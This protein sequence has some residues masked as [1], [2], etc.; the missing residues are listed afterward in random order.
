MN[1]LKA[2]R[3]RTHLL[4]FSTSCCAVSSSCCI[5][6]ALPLACTEEGEWYLRAL[7][8]LKPARGAAIKFLGSASARPLEMRCLIFDLHGVDSSL[9][10]HWRH[11]PDCEFLSHLILFVF[12]YLLLGL[13]RI[14]CL[15]V[16]EICLK[17]KSDNRIMCIFATI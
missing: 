10:Q 2:F 1:R 12:F 11:Q 8:V 17:L 9:Q 3:W 15:I 5:S 4:L 16:Y 7:A 6:P 14:L 13:A